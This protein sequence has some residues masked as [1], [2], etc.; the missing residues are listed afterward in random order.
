M[1]IKIL[2]NFSQQYFRIQ[3][4]YNDLEYQFMFIRASFSI[5]IKK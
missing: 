4:T 3:L 2:I 5:S 1:D